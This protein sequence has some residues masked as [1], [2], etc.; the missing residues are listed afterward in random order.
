MG[1]DAQKYPV[2]TS[3]AADEISFRTRGPPPK[4][5][6]QVVG[7]GASAGGLD[8]IR[9][10]L[11]AVPAPSEQ[12]FII[13]QHLDPT[14]ASM[15]VDLLAPH[16]RMTVVEAIAA[17]PIVANHVYVISPGKV[18]SVSGGCLNVST[19]TEPQ[20][21]RHLIDVLFAS[22][23]SEYGTNGAGIILSGTGTDGS[24]GAQAITAAG[25]LVIAQEP[26]E[27]KYAGMPDSAIAT[28]AVSRILVIAD[29]PKA[30]TSFSTR[31]TSARAA[32]PPS[33]S[34]FADILELI[35]SKT[36]HDFTDYKS[37]SLRRRIER[38]MAIANVE[39]QGM[40]GYLARLIDDPVEL[41]LLANDLLINVTCFFRDTPVFDLLGSKIIPDIACRMP[42]GEPIRVW[43]AGCS[44]GE[45]AYSL[46]IL[47][48]EQLTLRPLSGRPQIF[49]S[50]LDADAIAQAREGLF[51]VAIAKDVSKE[52]LERFFNKEEEGYRVTSELRACVVFTVQ[53]ILVD[54]PFSRLDLISCRNMLIYFS[55]VAQVRIIDLFHFALNPRGILLLGKAE[56]ITEGKDRFE[57]VD[58][59]ARLYR[60]I[61]PKSRPDV[62]LRG[63]IELA[64]L[65][66]AANASPHTGSKATALGNLARQQLI[67][68]FGPATVIVNRKGTC[69]FS[70][71]AANR[72]LSMPVGAPTQD[73]Y[74]MTDAALHAKLRTVIKR[75]N[76]DDARVTI[77]VGKVSLADGVTS[78]SIS[79][80][81]I[82][83]DGERL[84]LVSFVE[85]PA[86][87]WNAAQTPDAQLTGVESGLQEELRGVKADLAMALRD[88][89]ISNDEQKLINEEALSVNQE[90]QTANEELLA[91]K[92]E[93]QSVNE[94]LS[95]L[96][97][98]LQETLERQRT[99]SNDLQ[100]VLYST[101]VA[102]LFLDRMLRIRFFTPG[103]QTLFKMI[104]SDVGRPLTDLSG[105]AIDDTFEADALAVLASHKS[106]EREVQARIGAWYLR[107][108][109]PYRTQSGE[110]EGVVVTFTDV[111]ERHRVADSLQAAKRRAQQADAAKSRFLAAASHDLRQPLQTLTLLQGL[112]A[113]HVTGET[114]VRLVDRFDDTLQSMTAMLNTLLDINLIE[115]GTI[116]AE[117]GQ[118]AI[119]PLLRRIRDEF[120]YL[121]DARGLVLRLVPSGLDVVSD[122][123]LLEQMIRNIVSN[124]FKYTQ[125][126]K[127]L[128]GCRRHGDHI[129]IEIWDS[130]LGIPESELELIFE[131]YHQIDNA[132][133]ER[134]NGLG[135]GLAIVKR[136]ATM[137]N[138]RVTVRSRLGKGSVFTIE[139]R[140]PQAGQTKATGGPQTTA[141]GD[142]VLSALSASILVVEDDPTI[143]TLLESVLAA[144]GH[145]VTTAG[146]GPEA[147]DMISRNLVRPDLILADYNLPKDMN[148]VQVATSA[149][150]LSQKSLPVIILS[151]DISTETLAEISESTY[152]RLAKPV[153]V[154]ALRNAVQTQLGRDNRIRHDEHTETPDAD[155][156]S[157][158]YIVDDD[159]DLRVILR[160]VIESLGH[161]VADFS[162]CE[163][164]LAAFRPGREACLLLDA[165]LPGMS[166]IGLLKTFKAEERGLPTIMITGNS[167]VAIAVEAMKAGACDFLEKPIG[168]QALAA[169]IARAFI[170]ARQGR[171][172]G[173][174]RDAAQQHL[175]G[176]TVRQHQVMNMILS[177]IPNKNIAADLGISQRTVENHRA[178]IMKRTGSKSLPDLVRI[179]LAS[180]RIR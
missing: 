113:H 150:H 59:S 78:L 140:A 1:Q 169:S 167:D 115:S 165:T 28:G 72:F 175:M 141:A 136:L 5:G 90:Y 69:V 40:A 87:L 39:E 7:V 81:P 99:I 63:N 66:P 180:E 57:V 22:I 161:H 27:A 114:A 124:A 89:K 88:L 94:E 176:L 108:I 76:E 46:A 96:N 17:A 3:S 97:T 104:P 23:A 2:N 164:F 155:L 152:F 95:A 55:A 128:L 30:I 126:G 130:G 178:E 133:R 14:H 123:G 145:K 166:G 93:L 19:P 129:R 13:V 170:L 70:L 8:A 142:R 80:G 29:M 102:T 135:L 48:C 143:R 163:A 36:S 121:A 9:K 120:S 71:G 37:G 25:G 119:D 127:I 82:L 111:S 139:T 67:E 173:D 49:A 158:V 77:P 83:S 16:T 35:R 101:D 38:R 118:F 109:L 117:I 174:E 74:A 131:E 138:H 31:P 179:V 162:S 105:I 33:E 68:S 73:L 53:D 10:L 15:M 4:S 56:T 86:T 11:E 172:Q 116:G 147:L 149:R 12:A 79:A 137:L 151:G 100:N 122:P 107:R 44:T 51:P 171:Q 144:D 32:L 148:G 168:E 52:R 18:L 159:D 91:S 43:V 103:S 21:A 132:A 92:E 146:D 125:K 75:A 134:K 160:D 84:T 42:A 54:P 24:A 34:A 6:V 156:A 177:G 41:D 50:D 60:H 157:I 98:Q 58:K 65:Q 112:L 154:V 47:L 153:T 62:N 110:V 45:E 106:S 61:G 64:R 20:G 85:A 26:R